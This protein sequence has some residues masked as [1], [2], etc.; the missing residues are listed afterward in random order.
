MTADDS[1][2]FR[3]QR[4]RAPQAHGELLQVPTLAEA[5]TLWEKNL[6]RS[7]ANST[8]SIGEWSLTE[9][10]STGRREIFKLATAYTSQ[11]L[12]VDLNGRSQER[13]VMGGHQPSLFHPG[14]W[15]KN[16]ALSKLSGAFDCTSINLIVD[17]DICGTATIR[18]P[19]IENSDTGLNRSKIKAHFASIPIDATGPNIPFENRMVEDWEFFEDFPDRVEKAIAPL[20]KNPLVRRLWDQLANLPKEF[21]SK[22]RLGQLLAMAR[23]RLENEAGLR[24]L[25]LPVSHLAST[26]CF[27]R[28]V[29]AIICHAGEFLNTYNSSLTDY[30][31]VHKIRSSSHPVPALEESDGW[32]E[33]PFWIWQESVPKRRRMFVNANGNCFQFSDKAGLSVEIEKKDFVSDFLALEKQGISVR[34]KAL[35]TTMFS[36]L[37]LSDLFVHGIGGAKYDQLTDAIC[38]RFFGAVPPSFITMS[39]TMKIS[40]QFELFGTK[41]QAKA[42]QHNRNLR[43]HPEKFLSEMSPETALLVAEK[44]QWTHGSRAL[45]KSY[46]RH[47]AI[48]EINERLRALVGEEDA[49]SVSDRDIR[50]SEILNSRENSFVIFPE[51]LI[52]QLNGIV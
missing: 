36:R 28:F 32:I 26:E 50:T 25:E 40:H 8:V 51:E 22:P 23:H 19:K 17:N 9:L 39:A 18:Y 12:D 29:E 47:S 16:F 41:D 24:T 33:T 13:L 5:P 4:L 3:Y 34:P 45:D 21:R 44:A 27:G 1:V 52:A 20:V 7:A 49:Q 30:R 42:K 46:Q 2:E 43:F 35:M 15:I 10:Q 37:L 11:Y 31:K 14:V 6:T 48:G 38:S